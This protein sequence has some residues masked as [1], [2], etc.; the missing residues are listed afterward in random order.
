[1]TQRCSALSMQWSCSIVPQ[2]TGWDR[3]MKTPHFFFLLDTFATNIKRR[4]RRRRIVGEK[5]KQDGSNLI[6]VKESLWGRAECNA[7]YAALVSISTNILSMI[8]YFSLSPAPP[9]FILLSIYIQ[10][11]EHLITLSCIST[12]SLP[13]PLPPLYSALHGSAVVQL[14]QCK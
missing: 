5:R 1:M 13:L 8:I 12:P 11:P 14:F 6:S 2:P 3:E 7:M 9:S 4:T 10:I